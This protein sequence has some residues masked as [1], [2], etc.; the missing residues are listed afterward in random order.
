MIIFIDFILER[1]VND[2]AQLNLMTL[3]FLKQHFLLYKQGRLRY[4][5]KVVYP[6]KTVS[7]TSIDLIHTLC[8]KFTLPHN[9]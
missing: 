6:E 8:I 3:T 2:S 4:T 1:I 7:Y 9:S 5:G